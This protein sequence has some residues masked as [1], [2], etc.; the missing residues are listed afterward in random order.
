MADIN[1]P[2]DSPFESDDIQKPS[3]TTGRTRRQLRDKGPIGRPRVRPIK[4]KSGRGPGRPRFNSNDDLDRQAIIEGTLSAKSIAA[5]SKA[6]TSAV[7]ALNRNVVTPFSKAA[8]SFS[9]SVSTFNS[10]HQAYLKQQNTMLRDL[11]DTFKDF[12]KVSI[13]PLLRIMSKAHKGSRTL[14][15]VLGGMNAANPKDV[16]LA[17]MY[18][19]MRRNDDK[20][21]KMTRAS[22][23]GVAMTESFI[24]ETYKTNKA[25]SKMLNSITFAFEDISEDIAALRDRLDRKKSVVDQTK[26]LKNIEKTIVGPSP[27]KKAL[28][29]AFS[30]A[31]GAGKTAFKYN[32]F[33]TTKLITDLFGF[34]F[35][36]N[37]RS[38]PGV[39]GNLDR[40][41]DNLAKSLNKYIP[42]S[43][44]RASHIIG[45]YLQDTVDIITRRKVYNEAGELV[46]TAPAKA[47]KTPTKMGRKA[48]KAW[49]KATTGAYGNLV[50][51]VST[52]I[53]SVG[54]QAKDI[55]DEIRKLPK[56]MVEAWDESAIKQYAKYAWEVGSTVF[57]NTWDRAGAA[58]ERHV[59][60][61]ITNYAKKDYRGPSGKNQGGKSAEEILGRFY[62]DVE[63]YYKGGNGSDIRRLFS[64]RDIPKRAKGG[65]VRKNRLH[66]VGENGPE[67]FVPDSFGEILNNMDYQMLKAKLGAQETF[68]NIKTKGKSKFDKFFTEGKKFVNYD[69]DGINKITSGSVATARDAYASML[70]LLS[71]IEGSIRRLNRSVVEG[72]MSGAGKVKEGASGLFGGMG[73]I[74]P[75]L[76]FAMSMLFNPKSV[77]GLGLFKGSLFGQSK[78]GR[79]LRALKITQAG[80]GGKMA[81]GLGGALTWGLLSGFDPATMLF[82]AISGSWGKGRIGKDFMKGPGAASRNALKGADAVKVAKNIPWW[83]IPGRIGGA[84]KDGYMKYFAYSPEVAKQMRL[85]KIAKANT[86][87]AKLG[88][89][90]GGAINQAKFGIEKF[91]VSKPGQM[92][93][94]G[95]RAGADALVEGI[96]HLFKGTH[97]AM[98]AGLAK[99]P[100]VSKLMGKAGAKLGIKALS[101]QIPLLGILIGVGFAIWRLTKGQF[102]EAAMELASGV[103]G[104]LGGGFGNAA[105]IG[106]DIEL[107][108][109][110]LTGNTSDKKPKK[111]K[112][113]TT[114]PVNKTVSGKVGDGADTS[115][116]DR[117]MHNPND[118]FQDVLIKSAG[119]GDKF[120]IFVKQ[121]PKHSIGSFIRGAA[122]SAANI[123]SGAAH[124]VSGA[125]SNVAANVK[126]TWKDIT[127]AIDW[128][129]TNHSQMNPK[130]MAR[131]GAAAEAFQKA[132]GRRV[133]VNSAIRTNEDQARLWVRANILHDPNVMMPALPAYD[134]VVSIGGREYAVKGS[135][136]TMRTG[137]M[138]GGAVDVQNWREF[139][140]Y[141]EKAGLT[142]M[143]A[144]DPVHFQI[145]DRLPVVRSSSS[146]APKPI[147]T[148]SST[149]NKKGVVGDGAK[150]MAQNNTTSVGNGVTTNPGNGQSQETATP[151]QILDYSL[152]IMNN[153]I[154]S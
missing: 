137:H 112:P 71:R 36:S 15:D 141:A 42:Q 129:G 24:K 72:A 66:I 28:T 78:P 53:E 25:V 99:I 20:L 113:K 101:K 93:G 48:R 44:T 109:R 64:D 98:A 103:A 10:Q 140:P 121:K 120:N 17:H 138:V 65:R 69:P 81:R 32:R 151:P 1:D 92:I 104:G 147:T 27:L 34:D 70:K 41:G 2:F 13:D 130:F 16:Q 136:R 123:V 153:L 38:G 86:P 100:G 57:L 21:E 90:F 46:S 45:Q 22:V 154:F 60:A 3:N 18:R 83:N 9:K 132:T 30:G 134:T 55:I 7:N 149:S 33:G 96:T 14:T 145:N 135:G 82:G 128:G 29:L 114:K 139:R 125:A 8:A 51:E 115:G 52:G 150:S 91:A 89:F 84:I 47:A 97:Q 143:G 108:R 40:F 74:A 118:P 122:S 152:A 80:F 56:N 67:L 79:M 94:K 106:L 76:P 61:T 26:A 144:N 11:H 58:G 124:A 59:N 127:G 35:N 119:F 102:V 50:A 75:W 142:W 63:E 107:A 23:A 110:D 88:R 117:L 111:V 85:D 6:L 131:F 39:L 95:A 146:Q 37:K 31:V 68:S 4:E 73:K 148:V 77:K 54:N 49:N 12:R 116:F 19:Q 43:I 5:S 133:K 105:A 87:L 62:S 126:S